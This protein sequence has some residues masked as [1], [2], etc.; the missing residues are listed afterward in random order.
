MR[1]E[2]PSHEI[3]A[4]VPHPRLRDRRYVAVPQERGVVSL[5]I[6]TNDVGS[7][8]TLDMNR[9][10]QYPTMLSRREASS[11]HRSHQ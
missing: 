4:K 2:S 3:T 10:R 5:N 6:R 11:R 1:T 9:M 8:S 7:R